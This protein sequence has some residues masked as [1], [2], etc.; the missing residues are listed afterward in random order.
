MR[1]PRVLFVDQSAEMGGAELSL[2]DIATAR[3]D[4]SAVAL[5]ADGVFRERLEAQGVATKLFT[6]GDAAGFSRDSGLLAAVSG[7]P[8]LL[9]VA[10]ALA[11]YGRSFDLI[12]ANTQKALVLS[13]LA[14]PMARRPLVWH[15]RDML[16]SEHFGKGVLKVAVGL[17]NRFARCVV[18][19]SEATAQSFRDAGGKTPVVVVHNGIDPSAFEAVDGD[20]AQQALR[21]E[22]RVPEAPLV[23]VFSRLA[24]WK[25]Q[26]ILIEALDRLPGVHAVFVGGS[27]F[28]ERAYE[29]DLRKKVDKAG[30]TDRVHFLGY[31]GDIPALMKGVDII[32]HTSIAPEPFGRVIVEGM[33]AG[34]AVIGARAG[35][36]LEIIEP[37]RTGLWSEPG[38]ARSLAHAISRLLSDPEFARRIARNGEQAARTRFSLAACI[39]NVEAVIA[40]TARRARAAS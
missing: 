18:A 19:N 33:L 20:A 31:R 10:F 2:L 26:H 5:L 17:T 30:L 34:R 21:S 3:K 36:V 24:E 32:A 1:A 7:V 40:Q 38:D 28:G 12:Y 25:G 6:L 39:D 23:G 8:K 35:G 13:A 16:T 37:H 22:I 4:R 14:A 9:S 11:R 29:A 27:L 15:L